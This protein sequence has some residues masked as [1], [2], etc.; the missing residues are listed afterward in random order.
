LTKHDTVTHTNTHVLA[1]H[2][3]GTPLI[4]RVPIDGTFDASLLADIFASRA[5]EPGEAHELHDGLIW[6]LPVDPSSGAKCLGPQEARSTGVPMKM[7]YVSDSFRVVCTAEL[8]PEADA[9]AEE[10]ELRERPLLAVDFGHAVWLEALD[11][12]ETEFSHA[13]IENGSREIETIDGVVLAWDERKVRQIKQLRFVSFPPICVNEEGDEVPAPRRPG[14]N[15]PGVVRTLETP[16]GLNLDDV[17]TINVD[18]SQGAILLSVKS[19]KIWVLYY[20]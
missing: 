4:S 8:D 16:E 10:P 17:E 19:G 11:V 12:Y 6:T 7:W 20:E 15:Q 2:Y 1:Q 5:T 14:P 13:A 9:A 18:Q 3:F